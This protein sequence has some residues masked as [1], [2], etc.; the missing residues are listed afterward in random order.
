MGKPEGIHYGRTRLLD[1]LDIPLLEIEEVPAPP[2]RNPRVTVRRPAAKVRE[3]PTSE[4]F[5]RLCRN[6]DAVFVVSLS[7]SDHVNRTHGTTLKNKQTR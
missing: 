1:K 7:F 2:K 3:P 4:E 6:P 5:I